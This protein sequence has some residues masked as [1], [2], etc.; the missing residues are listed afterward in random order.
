MSSASESCS[1]NA[2]GCAS[3]STTARIAPP[4]PAQPADTMNAIVWVRPTE[5]PHS[6]AAI[7]SSRTARIDRP[8]PLP[9]TL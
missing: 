8:T 7:S 5:S 2:P 9:M 3:W 6:E 1:G 4:R